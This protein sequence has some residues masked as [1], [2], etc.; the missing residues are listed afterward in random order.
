MKE[1][2]IPLCRHCTLA[3]DVRRAGNDLIPKISATEYLIWCE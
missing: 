3:V 1:I 2:T